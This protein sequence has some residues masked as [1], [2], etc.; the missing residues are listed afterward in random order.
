MIELVIHPR[1]KDLAGLKWGRVLPPPA[2]R[3]S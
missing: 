3:T 2:S 1:P